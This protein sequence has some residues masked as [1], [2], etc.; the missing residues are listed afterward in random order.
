MMEPLANILLVDDD[1]ELLHLLDLSLSKNNFLVAKA[2]NWEQVVEEIEN[3]N[4]NGQKF[5]L[6][7]LDFL[8]PE[9]SGFEMLESLQS[10]LNPLP[11]VII[12]SA[13]SGLKNTFRVMEHGVSK[14]LTKPISQ[15]KLLRNVREILENIGQEPG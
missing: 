14:F 12:L 11:P 10:I 1:P 6:I 13:V 7:I 4:L 3:L 15:I 9:R 2:S 5:D 8:M